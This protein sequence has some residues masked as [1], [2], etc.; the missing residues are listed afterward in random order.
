MELQNILKHHPSQ[1][2][3]WEGT[4]IKEPVERLKSMGINS[5]VYDPC[6]NTPQEGDFL[7]IMHQNVENLQRAFP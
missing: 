7:K 5:L 6:G 3:I 2:M 1:W 4:P